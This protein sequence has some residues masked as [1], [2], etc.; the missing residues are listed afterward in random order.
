MAARSK[1]FA[2]QSPRSGRTSGGPPQTTPGNKRAFDA[3]PKPSDAERRDHTVRPSFHA[4]QES[5]DPL[6]AVDGEG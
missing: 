5:G 2:S 3:R 4:D 1:D 6:D